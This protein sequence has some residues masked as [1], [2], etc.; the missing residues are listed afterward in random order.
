MTIPE[1]KVKENLVLLDDLRTAQPLRLKML[2]KAAGRLTF[3]SSI[4]PNLRPFLRSMRRALA[5]IERQGPI[6]SGPKQLA[7]DIQWLTAFFSED[8]RRAQ[9]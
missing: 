5:D 9:T 6:F 3:V 1:E 2:R 8:G 7:K 4:I